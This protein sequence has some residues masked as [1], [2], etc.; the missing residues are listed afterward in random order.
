MASIKRFF[1]FLSLALGLIT[2]VGANAVFL[3][4]PSNLNELKVV[5]G[6]IKNTAHIARRAR[7]G[8]PFRGMYTP[9]S[10][11]FIN[12]TVV[13]SDILF[14]LNYAED[15]LNEI[16][17]APKGSIAEVTYH[18]NGSNVFGLEIN[19]VVIEKPED[20]LKQNQRYYK[21][22][23]LTAGFFIAIAVLLATLT[24]SKPKNRSEHNHS[25][26]ADTSKKLELE[27]DPQPFKGVL[28]II[29]LVAGG[30]WGAMFVRWYYLYVVPKTD[31]GAG[32][33]LFMLI[34][35][36]P[37]ILG[38]TLGYFFVML[39]ARPIPSVAR[40]LAVFMPF[41]IAFF[42]FVLP[43]QI[44]SAKSE[45]YQKNALAIRS[46][47]ANQNAVAG[48]AQQFT[49]K[50]LGEIFALKMQTP[51]AAPG[52]I[53]SMLSVSPSGS[54]FLIGN[55]SNKPIKVEIAR[56]LPVAGTWEHCDIG[57]EDTPA[58]AI[59]WRYRGEILPGHGKIYNFETCAERFKN[60]SI[61]YVVFNSTGDYIFRSESSFYRRYP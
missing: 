26:S 47:A 16:E 6:P 9:S 17:N 21:Q 41:L 40:V 15:R 56:V 11:P 23:Y 36:F 30:L 28:H 33:T 22:L 32:G 51:H 10:E 7:V 27:N 34:T 43:M 57:F 37:L 19:G 38:I 52:V 1:F 12:L 42:G 53:P 3:S 61:E 8:N 4:T 55:R 44:S 45:Q 39:G 46:S 59:S 14:K 48:G 35:I 50:E 20:H 18:V 13:G 25:R 49:P 31:L 58:P 5:T 24:K 54:G 29:G 60:A 2:F